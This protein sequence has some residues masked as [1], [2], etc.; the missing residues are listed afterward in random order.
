MHPPE[1]RAA[2]A[3][4]ALADLVDRHL[5]LDT[6]LNDLTRRIAR[7]MDAERATL[8][9]VDRA[10]SE[11]FSIAGVLP[12][13]PEIRLRMGQGVAGYVAE[14]GEVVNVPRT[15]EDT[16][17]CPE[18]DKRTGF[19]T[20]SLLAA[21]VLAGNGQILG[22]IQLLNKRGGAFTRVDE[23]TVEALA[24]QTAAVVEATTLPTALDRTPGAGDDRIVV[25][26]RFD[27]LIG[28]S[29]A[30]REV[31][32]NITRAARTE[33]T[34]LLQGDSGTGKERVVLALHANSPRCEGRL[35]KVDCAAIPVAL[36]E[37]ELFGHE[38]GAYTGAD[39]RAEGKVAAAS[40][41]T[42]FLDE[43]GEVPLEAQG[44][45]LRLLQ[46][47][48]FER[49]GGTEPVTAD[50]RVVA[51]THRDLEAMVEE[52]RFRRDLY[53]RL[54]VVPI[55][56]PTLRERGEV[57]LSLLVRHFLSSI[58]R[59][60]RRSGLRL[61]DAAWDR[62]R[63]HTWPGNVRELEHCIE[64][65]V[66]LTDGEIIDADDLSLPI[67]RGVSP[68]CATTAR[69]AGEPQTLEAVER[70]H[71]LRVLEETGGNRARAASMLGIGRN[72]LARKLKA[73]GCERT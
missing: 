57:D 48:V 54:K 26:E 5:A 41:G 56:L 34:V 71:I 63:A 50:V 44:K 55:R 2:T 16:R 7:V 8:F 72:T 3:I 24:R 27:G 32:R 9:L 52:G 12:E 62:L 64:S 4:V 60:H 58:G 13:I 10:R 67:G 43:V 17:F 66:V 37:N 38:R 25:E 40:G 1:Q 39:R 35:V 61:S 65:A 45:L 59:R 15:H 21:P 70:A 6:L 18:T 33:A 29:A 47:R 42:L 30:M 51:A 20:D 49:V 22:V 36:M 11:V 53:Y 14:S 19:Q 68:A 23:L 69:A 73:W 46:D 28:E 31:F